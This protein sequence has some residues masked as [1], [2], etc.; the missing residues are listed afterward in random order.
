LTYVILDYVSYVELLI[1]R[2]LMRGPAHGYE[3]RKHVEA[4]TGVLLHNNALYPAL[5]RF[6]E[7]GAVTKTAQSQ[8]G[9]PPRHVY[10]ITEVGR[11]LLHDM[12]TE[13]PPG[14]ADDE[15]EFFARVAQFAMLHPEERL[16][17]LAAREAAVRR[18]LDQ[19]RSLTERTRHELWGTQV[20]Q[21]LIDQ[22]G[23]ELAWLATMRE[24]A[25][26]APVVPEG[27]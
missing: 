27:E 16:A 6:T 24:V 13:L 26:S 21:R 22:C 8:Q 25:A 19:L 12:L 10:L 7:A 14:R 4:N 20:T 15:A 2:H 1:L 9:R 3:L 23:A 11:E 18:R 17:V 5:H